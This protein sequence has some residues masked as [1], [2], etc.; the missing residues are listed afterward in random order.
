MTPLA[1]AKLVGMLQ[2]GFPAARATEA[3]LR[4]YEHMLLDLDEEQARNAVA[5]LLCVSR[6]FP[7]IAEIR[8]GTA[9]QAQG[10]SR[11]GLEAWADVK[12]AIRRTG[13]VDLPTFE[14]PIVAHCVRCLGWRELCL[15]ETPEGVDR[16]NFVRLYE[17]QQRRQRAYDVSEPG[18][19]LPAS[20]EPGQLPPN[21]RQLTEGIAKG[22][23]QPNHDKTGTEKARRL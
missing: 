23:L 17:E 11:S 15:G 14:D 5:K 9:D 22:Q 8:E 16:A 13:Y 1:A 20:T 10:P 3:T 19:L 4:L 6:F 12:L 7:T 2:A 18:R 21:V